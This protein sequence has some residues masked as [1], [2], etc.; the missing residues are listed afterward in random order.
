MAV[1]PAIPVSEIVRVTPS[2]ISA[3]GNGLD[4]NGLIL[5]TDWRPPIGEVQEFETADNVTDYFG[6][7]SQMS[8]LGSIYF[9]GFDNSL[10]KPGR[11]L[12]AQFP[13]VAVGAYLR[14]GAISSLTTL[15]AISGTL[16]VNIDGTSYDGT[17]NL[18]AQTS[19]SN[20]AYYLQ[21]QLAIPNG[22][23][24]ASV[25]GS[26]SGTTLTVDS[27]VSGSLAVGQVLGG[28]AVAGGTYVTA[29][30]TG[31]GGAGTYTVS[32]SQ[33]VGSA[34]ITGL[35]PG[36]YYDPVSHAFV[37]RS[38]V[39]SAS[40]T[41]GFATGTA[42]AGLRLTDATGA[43]ISPGADAGTAAG[44]LNAIMDITQNWACFMTAWEPTDSLKEDFASWNNSRGNRFVYAMADTSIND[45]QAGGPSTAVQAILNGTYAGIEL[46][47][48]NP[49]VD[50]VGGQLSAFFLGY[51]ASIDFTRTNG[52]TTA[53]FRKQSGLAAQVVDATEAGYLRDYGMNFY[54][55]YTTADEAFIFYYPGTIT[56][57]FLWADSYLNQVWFNQQLQLALITFLSQARS[58]PYNRVGYTMIESACMDPINQALNFGLIQ[59]GVT[60]AESQKA[61]VNNAAGFT[62]DPIITQRGWYLL[63][64]DAPASVRIERG[65][66]PCTLF[67]TDG[68]SV[69]SI[70]LASI[71]VL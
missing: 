57:D 34:S 62:I 27:V 32:S 67:Y 65:S 6:E 55:S 16:T 59:P 42:A 33:T 50:T 38:A 47:Y 18:S 63:I 61:Q 48:E 19:F 39:L 29:L 26:I 49:E 10:I 45:V 21:T 40:S 2:V 43:V 71:A 44:V 68:Q 41:I 69:Q 20:A 31:T 46:I 15:Q 70:N 24:Q 28:T 30:I 51:A 8:A 54:G 13:L 37:I 25:V 58:V 14:S 66:P 23:T 56:G 17:V 9:L 64:Q 4:L 5:T 36:V 22:A 7:M 53:A 1:T 12:V 35:V 52:R 3:A 60:L 11:L